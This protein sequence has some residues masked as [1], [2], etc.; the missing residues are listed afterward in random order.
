M[1]FSRSEAIYNC[2]LYLEYHQMPGNKPV[3]WFVKTNKELQD[4]LGEMDV[5]GDEEAIGVVDDAV[6]AK[7]EESLPP[8]YQWK[9]DEASAEM[10]WEMKQKKGLDDE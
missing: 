2:I 6:F 10:L 8:D 4:E 1:L 5:W 3:D 9:Y 7:L